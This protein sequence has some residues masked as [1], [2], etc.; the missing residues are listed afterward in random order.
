M[1]EESGKPTTNHK[2]KFERTNIYERRWRRK[3]KLVRMMFSRPFDNIEQFRL[4]HITKRWKIK[5]A[6]QTIF[7]FSVMVF[8]LS[9]DFFVRHTY[10]CYHE[11]ASFTSGCVHTC[12]SFTLSA[13]FCFFVFVLVRWSSQCQSV[14]TKMNWQ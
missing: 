5:E 3:T 11:I 6:N 7:F 8:V 10:S 4:A 14:V 12:T 2:K 1:Y 9:E 13:F